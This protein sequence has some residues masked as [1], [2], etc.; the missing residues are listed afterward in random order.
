MHKR[1]RNRFNLMGPELNVETCWS[2][3]RV[4]AP[5]SGH[6][7]TVRTPTEGWG[8]GLEPSAVRQAWD[9]KWPTGVPGL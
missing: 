6:W 4:G 1:N 3:E 8:R 7:A 2:P 9:H 5:K